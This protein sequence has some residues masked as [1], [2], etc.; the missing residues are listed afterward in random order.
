[1]KRLLALLLSSVLWAGCAAVPPQSA[2]PA[3]LFVDAAFGPPGR[4]VEAAQVFELSPAMRRYLDVDI[5][6]MLRRYGRHRGLVEALYSRE[7]LRLEYD[8]ESTR[9][10]AQAFEARAGNCLSL[11]VMTA[12][13]AKALDLPV[14]YQ[15]L[16]GQESWS[17]SANLTIAS[18]HVNITV[19]KRLVD[20]IQ[21]IETGAE[22]QLDFGGLGVGRSAGLRV[23][24]ER[25]IVAMFM[26]NRA[27]ESL[28]R[29]DI[30]QAY[31]YVREAVRQDPGFAGAFNTLGVIYRQRG[32]HAAAE[33]VWRHALGIQG[34]G[35]GDHRAT[36]DNLAQLLEAQGRAADAAPLRQALHRIERE[37][38]FLQFDLG[39]AAL[40]H[41]DYA[42]ARDHL[43]RALASDPDYHEFHFWLAQALAGLGD[44][45][46]AARHLSQAMDM[47]TTRR[48]HEIYAGKLDRLRAQV[49]RLN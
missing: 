34:E 2:A 20:R 14:R 37:P 3:S 26:N 30:A 16:E 10:A 39:R 29:G 38:P 17:R 31:A 22:L 12:A 49:S 1:M 23:V 33:A 46:G 19:G 21:G 32:L 13:F 6:P 42:Q 11:V 7:H 36:L 25:T 27:A 47:S 45:Q 18:G 44:A 28:V 35:S 9:T 15:V 4:P 5:A 8:T 43:Q 41:G 48:D 24:E 40:A